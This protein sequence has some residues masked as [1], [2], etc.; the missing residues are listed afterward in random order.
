MDS[1]TDIADWKRK[2][3]LM[4][5]LHTWQSTTGESHAVLN[6]ESRCINRDAVFRVRVGISCDTC[7]RCD[8]VRKAWCFTTWLPASDL[9]Y[10]CVGVCSCSS[11]LWASAKPWSGSSSSWT[12]IRLHVDLDAK[13]VRV[14]P[15]A[16]RRLTCKQ[17][18]K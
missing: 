17:Y 14:R 12:S 8:Q 3:H 16:Q 13:V 2:L 11:P 6:N 4:K 5:Q 1:S 18:F 15:L 9:I 7:L 10:L